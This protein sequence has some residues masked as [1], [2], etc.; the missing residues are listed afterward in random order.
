MEQNK[1]QT[2][3]TKFR[4]LLWL[5]VIILVLFI[6]NLIT[7][8]KSNSSL[9]EHS[10]G[11]LLIIYIF[12]FVVIFTLFSI[13]LF[14]QVKYAQTILKENIELKDEKLK[15]KTDKK[16]KERSKE[17]SNFEKEESSILDEIWENVKKEKEIEKITESFLIHLANKVEIVQGLFYLF[18]KKEK[19]FSISAKYAYYSEDE[20][21]SFDFGEGL[22]GQVAKDMKPMII[23]D[24][25]E[26]Y[27]TILSGLGSSAPT[28][29]LIL[30][31]IQKN[32]TIGIVE[33]ASFVKID[34]KPEAFVEFF[35]GISDNLVDDK[36]K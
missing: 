5:A 35:K 30:P 20:P 16:E 29:L 1:F 19:K 15:I 33:L 25:P 22:S 14:S 18:D 23:N 3:K 34:I 31:V 27:M 32:K 10:S 36:K 2:Y 28:N 11:I 7:V 13:N 26:K 12:L 4:V 9:M 6:L 24:L 8:F 17:E 21:V